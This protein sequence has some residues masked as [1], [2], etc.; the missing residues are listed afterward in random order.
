[1]V[2]ETPGAVD[3]SRA[4]LT[5]LVEVGGQFENQER[6]ARHRGLIVPLAL[7]F[8]SLFSISWSV[9]QSIR[10]IFNFPFTPTD[11]AHITEFALC[12]SCHTPEADARDPQGEPVGAGPPSCCAGTRP[13][14]R[15]S[16]HST[17]RRTCGPKSWP[18]INGRSSPARR[19]A[20][21]LRSACSA[22]ALR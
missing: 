15:P 1:M 8:P 21:P 11:G 13:R 5:E 22:G 14:S 10:I 16:A 9:R 4:P 6:A 7:I 3:V 17:T 18:W 19:V 2:A 12:G 20:R